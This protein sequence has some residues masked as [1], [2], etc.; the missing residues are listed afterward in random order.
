M[1]QKSKDL[2]PDAGLGTRAVHAG[3]LHR[4][5]HHAITTPVVS[6]A[7]Y[8]FDDTAALRDYFEG[9]VRARGVRPLRQPHR[10]GGRAQAGRAGRRRRGGGVRQRHGRRHHHAAGAAEGGRPHGD[11]L[12]LLPAHPAVRDHR[13][14]RY[15]VT[16]TLVEPGDFAGLEKALHAG[17]DQGHP[18]R[19]AHQPV[20]AGGRP[21]QAGRPSSSASAAPSWS[22]TPPS[23]RRSTSGRWRPAP[24]W[25]S[26]RAPSTWAATTTCWRAR[27][28]ATRGWSAPCATCAACWARCWIP[29]SAYLLLRGLKTLALRVKRQNESALRIARWLEEQPQ[30]ERVFYPG[31]PSHPDHAVAKRA[32]DRLRRRGQLPGQGRPGRDLARSSTAA[33]WR[34]S[35]PRWA[36]SRRLIEQPALMSFYELTHRAARGGGHPQQPGAHVGGPGGRDDIIADLRQALR[37]PVSGA[38]HESSA[39][40]ASAT[41]AAVGFGRLARRRRRAAR[42]RCWT[43]IRCAGSRRPPGARLALSAVQLLVPVPAAED[44]GGGAQLPQPPR[45]PPRPDPARAVLEAGVGAAGSRAAPSCCRPSPPTCTSRASWCWSS[46]GR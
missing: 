37:R 31:L 38:E 10:A 26:T 41:G 23:P 28:A 11:D 18:V 15:G 24:T 44:P 19:V 43:A 8:V 25:S 27:C 46:A 13:P 3:E 42:S 1:S 22:S 16:A 33:G 40:S 4:N 6:S 30:V 36:G 21:A 9:R 32:D 39:S 17:Q 34:R 20:P 2:P 7:T 5:P 12:G 29:H 35:P 45:H 14:R